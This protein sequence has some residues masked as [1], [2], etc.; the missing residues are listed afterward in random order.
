MHNV[1][2]LFNAHLLGKAEEKNGLLP[3]EPQG[4]Q[5]IQTW[6]CLSPGEGL[7]KPKCGSGLMICP[8][9][10]GYLQ[11]LLSGQGAQAI[12]PSQEGPVAE[13]QGEK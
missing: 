9:F 4:I 13:K 1:Q 5:T 12:H 6:G 10:F 8:R 11:F 2:S 7:E 3:T